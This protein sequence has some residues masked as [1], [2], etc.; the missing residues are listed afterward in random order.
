[1]SL[2]EVNEMNDE[3]ISWDCHGTKVPR[4]DNFVVVGADLSAHFRVSSV[5]FSKFRVGSVVVI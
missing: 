4:N 2:R 1:M 3:A 5:C